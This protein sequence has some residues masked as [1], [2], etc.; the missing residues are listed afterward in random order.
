M[1]STSSQLTVHGRQGSR[2]IFGLGFKAVD[3]RLSTAFIVLCLLVTFKP[4]FGQT[5]T[6]GADFLRID[7]GARSEGMGGAFTAVADDVNALTWNPAGLALL[8]HPEVGYL[9][10]IYI[11]DIS[12]NFGG[13]ALPIAEGENTIGL[14][15]GVINMGV[16]SF[17][18]TL[19]VASPVS[20]GDNDFFIS[21]A[22]RIKNIISF[23]ITGKNVLR[24]LAGYNAGAFGG[25]FGVLVTPT[26]RLRIG[27]GIFNVGQA[28]QFISASDPLPTVARFGVAYEV[29]HIPHHS[30][31]L[32]AETDYDL[33][34]MTDAGA[35]GG[36]YWFDKTLAL[37]AGYAGDVYQQHWTAG[38]GFNLQNIAQ[39]DYAYTPVGTL[40]DTHRLSLIIRFGTETSANEALSGP[41]DLSAQSFEEGLSL[42]WKPSPS[43]DVVGY[44]LYVKKPGATSFAKVTNQ[45]MHQTSVKL[46]SL[47]GGQSYSFQVT[48][49]SAAGRESEPL[50]LSAVP[51]VH[52]ETT[53]ALLIS[54]PTGLKA[55]LKGEG[56][57]LTWDKA[58]SS[59][60]A[61]YSLYQV[62]D[63][64]KPS[65][66]LGK[67]IPQERVVLKKV[68]P[69][70]LYRF[71][72]V[73]LDKSG[74]ES[75]PSAPLAVK[76]SDLQKALAPAVAAPGHFKV[77]P[78]DS[79]ASLSWDAVPGVAGYNLYRSDDGKSFKLLTKKGPRNI[80]S[81]LLKPLK[82]GHAYY[83]AVTSVTIDGK[84]SQRTMQSVVPAP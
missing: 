9:R 71:A 6:S 75:A 22:Y 50:E 52:V 74:T 57:E 35:F 68:N 37:R 67:P 26:D 24:N 23:G 70:Q 49:V 44:D 60:L 48:S 42:S 13:V 36:E 76:W 78:G 11:S 84:E 61:A 65:K 38:V 66:K 20:A 14:G 21:G 28:V 53:Q 81:A 15:A 32:S 17:D 31:L 45:P 3:R 30:V 55:A 83:F 34:A 25:D 73:A 46:K 69:D 4:L 33:N 2:R 82:N 1:T 39:L 19:G 27:A 43:H 29:L 63:Q 62:D 8:Q 47:L 51:G 77:V 79:S 80:Q 12:Y 5:V 10:M 58:G 59:N 7:S 54:P 18:S 64:G 41:S 72:I 40:G 16:P 56:I